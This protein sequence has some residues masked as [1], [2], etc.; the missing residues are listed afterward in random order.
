VGREG[1]TADEA[2]C[3]EGLRDG[4]AADGML[5]P[6]ARILR[7][8]VREAVSTS[9]NA[10][11]RT[12]AEIDAVPTGDWE[13]ELRLSTWAVMQRGNEVLGIAAAKLPS[14]NDDIRYKE[15]ARF[16]ESVWI[17]PSMRGEKLGE[18]L[19]EYLIEVERK[20][21]IGIDQILLWVFIQNERAI[22]LYERMG[23][24]PT[25]R[26][27][28]RKQKPD[29][30]CVDEA[31]YRLLFDS[32]LAVAAELDEN[33]AARELDRQK[34]GVRYRLL[35]EE[36]AGSKPRWLKASTVVSACGSFVRYLRHLI[37][38]DCQE[39]TNL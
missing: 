25:Q 35:K 39:S 31:Q 16:I 33:A 1:M 4:P 6:D 30:T 5:S 22:R 29:G 11:L 20:K 21:G 2:E 37:R 3:D 23:F 27:T 12:V 24:K 38:S 19:I 36:I 9:P 18:R 13:D 28:Q 7:R 14:D 10:F 8:T 15:T 34:Y 32:S 26:P 17:A